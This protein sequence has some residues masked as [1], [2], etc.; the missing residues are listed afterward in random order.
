MTLEEF[1]EL[2]RDA[3]AKELFN[4]CGSEKWVALL[5]QDFPFASE[6]A[7]VEKATTAWYA[8]CNQSD[9][10][11]SFTHHPQIGDKKSLEQK[12]AGKE[13]AGVATAT[14]DVINALAK[15]NADY[16][17]KFGFIFIVCATGKQATEM[18]QLMQGRLGNT[19]EEEVNIAKGEQ[20]KITLIRFKKLLEK[21]NFQFLKMSQL[22]THVLDTSIGKPGQHINVKLLQLEAGNAQHPADWQLITQGVTDADGRIGDLLP[23]EKLLNPG[24][25]KLIFETGL[26]FFSNNIKSFYPEVEIQ[27]S[28]FDDAHYHVPLL[29]NPFGYST[30]R[31][32]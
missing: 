4:C 11:E 18:L 9:W 19:T 12:F 21:A 13:Q 27:F 28:V 22:T 6:K 30:Y 2:G 7:L 1:N 32:S 20:H 23:A 15:A 14:D 8:V 3:A 10:L 24:T 26:Y 31:G 17:Q 16:Q 25:Y 5:M 29:I